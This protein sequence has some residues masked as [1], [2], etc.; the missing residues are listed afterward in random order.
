M[1]VVLSEGP[2]IDLTGSGVLA[3]AVLGVVG[4]VALWVY[5]KRDEIAKAADEAVG[6]VN[7]AD[8]RNLAYGAVSSIGEAVTGREGWTL[9]SQ[10]ADWFP[11][12]A[13]RAFNDSMR[14]AVVPLTPEQQAFNAQPDTYGV[15]PYFAP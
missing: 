11:S 15:A 5:L 10:I 1:A 14:P 3:L 12:A 9:G 13:E 8:S 4:G 6:L 7:P 2:R